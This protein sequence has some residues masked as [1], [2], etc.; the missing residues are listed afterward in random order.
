M[1]KHLL[2][3][4]LFSSVAT[5]AFAQNAELEE[6]VPILTNRQ[7]EMRQRYQP[8]PA[9]TMSVGGMMGVRY[10]D[11]LYRSPTDKQGDAIAV[12]N[13]GLTLRSDMRPYKFRLDA[14]VESGRYLS[15]HDNAYNDA[16]MRGEM[17]FAVNSVSSLYADGRFRY[18]HVE[19]G[20]FLDRSDLQADEPTTYRYGEAGL[21]WKADNKQWLGKVDVRSL[22][23]NFDN[24]DRI[25]GTRLINDDR[26]YMQHAITGRV[27][28]YI[29][30]ETAWYVQGVVNKRNYGKLVDTTLLQSRDS[31]GYEALT[32][33][34]YGDEKKPLW[35]EAAIGYIRQNYDF[36]TLPDPSAMAIRGFVQLQ[37]QEKWRLRGEVSR[38]IREAVMGDT[39]AYLQSRVR[40]RA[41]YQLTPEW[42]VGT[43]LRYTE[44]DFQINPTGRT[45]SRI[46]HLWDGSLYADYA[47]TKDY[48]LGGE[49]VHIKR[50]SDDATQ[51]YDSNVVM[52][53]FNVNY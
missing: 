51:K 2:I 25:D 12:L 48:S 35:A 31:H 53:R 15:E 30:P 34:S 13:P 45:P 39:S 9:V 6:G 46:D 42:T 43:G 41:D 38:D 50:H 7:E 33:L 36:I 14:K 21:G 27:G 3:A 24:V 4:V 52:L 20:A 16:D 37:P 23:Y 49:Y 5:S 1:K 8:D 44:N 26:D 40:A 17:D 47:L 18:D 11:N 10:Q 19:I 28:R 29:A 32:G 22:F